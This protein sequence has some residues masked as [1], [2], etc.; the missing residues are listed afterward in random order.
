MDCVIQLLF[1]VQLGFSLSD[2]LNKTGI[3]FDEGGDEEFIVILLM[4]LVE[5]ARIVGHTVLSIDAG[6]KMK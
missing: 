2:S 1:I 3:E 5:I 6:K 4:I